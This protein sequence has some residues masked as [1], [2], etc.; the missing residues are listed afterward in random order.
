MTRLK[1][2]TFIYFQNIYFIFRLFLNYPEKNKLRYFANVSL[3]LLNFYKEG[4]NGLL[5]SKTYRIISHQ[6]KK[7]L[8]WIVKLTYPYFDCNH[9]FKILLKNLNISSYNDEI[10]IKE[11][12]EIILFGNMGIGNLILTLPFFYNLK[13]LFPRARLV[14]ILFNNSNLFKLYKLV[15]IIDDVFQLGNKNDS[16]SWLT[17]LSRL[18][19]KPDMSFSFASRNFFILTCLAYL[20]PKIRAGITSGGSFVGKFDAIHNYA[21][22]FDNNI[23]EADLKMSLLKLQNNSSLSFSSVRDL[24][25]FSKIINFDKVESK[26]IQTLKKYSLVDKNYILIVHTV[27]KF[28]GW[29]AFAS[30]RWK[31]IIRKLSS[32]KNF[33]TSIVLA[34]DTLLNGFDN[35]NEGV[36]GFRVVDT[37]DKLDIF[38]YMGIIMG[39][40]F[41]VGFDSSALHIAALLGVPSLG[42]YGPT[43]FKRSRA[44]SPYSITMKVDCKCKITSI[45]DKQDLLRIENCKN[46]CIDQ[47]SEKNLIR[48]ILFVDKKL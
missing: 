4:A 20:R 48:K 2:L 5:S 37:S 36:R 9:N 40:K 8:E 15:N 44:L 12:K 14:V 33:N 29:K 34:G 30:Y 3:F 39:A 10:K 43:D 28:Q 32:I 31:S 23:H 46:R 25:S 24:S 1:K 27:S 35:L 41:V 42:L 45:L 16:R 17:S 13:K 11:I 18:N 26:K 19:L 22:R 6:H 21:F 7:N 38:E 47:F